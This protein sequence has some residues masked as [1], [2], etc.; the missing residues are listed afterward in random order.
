MDKVPTEKEYLDWLAHPVTVA[1]RE[2][3][4]LG[5][6]EL[7]EQWAMGAMQNPRDPVATMVANASAL[8]Q[9]QLTRRQLEMDYKEF[10]AGI[11]ENDDE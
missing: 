6:A 9:A 1:H 11:T 2:M 8:A 10:I 4:T 7:K 3:L 5:L